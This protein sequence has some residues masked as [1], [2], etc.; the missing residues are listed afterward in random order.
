MINMQ[1]SINIINSYLPR[2]GIFKV[3]GFNISGVR[4]F[5]NNVHVRP[6]FCDVM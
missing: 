5:N 6:K 1:N 2:P 3:N 4:K